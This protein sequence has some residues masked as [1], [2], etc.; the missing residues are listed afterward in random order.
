M[1]SLIMANFG[2]TLS[3]DVSWWTCPIV[4]VLNG[5]KRPRGE[6]RGLE[7]SGDEKVNGKLQ[8]YPF[9]LLL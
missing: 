4:V 2:D 1:P 3:D 7:F 8:L 5:S 6:L 9:S